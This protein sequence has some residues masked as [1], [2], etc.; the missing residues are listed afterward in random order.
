L[1]PTGV[2]R[3]SWFFFKKQ[4][5]PVMA[6][7]M[8]T[9]FVSELDTTYA[10]Y[11][12]WFYFVRLTRSLGYRIVK[13]EW[14]QLLGFHNIIYLARDHSFADKGDALPPGTSVLGF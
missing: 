13:T 3:A 1:A 14:A 2:I 8:N 10:V 9:I 11:Y 5:F 6:E 4:N 12:D 7:D